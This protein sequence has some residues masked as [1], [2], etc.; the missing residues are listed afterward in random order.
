MLLNLNSSIMFSVAEVSFLW[1]SESSYLMFTS[2][3]S[4]DSPNLT[5]LGY[6]KQRFVFHPWLHP[7]YS[8]PSQ[9]WNCCVFLH[10]QHCMV[11]TLPMPNMSVLSHVKLPDKEGF[12]SLSKNGP[13]QRF[14][15]IKVFSNKASLENNIW[16]TQS[17]MQKAYLQFAQEARCCLMLVSSAATAFIGCNHF[18]THWPFSLHLLELVE[19]NRCFSHAKV[20]FIAHLHRKVGILY[21]LSEKKPI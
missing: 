14:L 16:V 21:K 10:A 17:C 5:R 12:A 2:A 11:R 13:P 9:C 19:K 15:T 3:R 18:F 4:R 7:R 8:N 20:T 6:E 1:P